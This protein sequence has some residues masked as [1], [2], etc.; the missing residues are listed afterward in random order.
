MIYLFNKK[1]HQESLADHFEYFIE[2]IL[3]VETIDQFKELLETI[4]SNKFFKIIYASLINIIILYK[5]NP[6]Q[7][8]VYNNCI[9]FPLNHQVY[10]TIL[11][12]SY[13]S[14][15]YNL[16]ITPMEPSVFEN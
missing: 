7:F 4:I 9:P 12:S 1:F 8:L 16:P 3:F 11:P 2:L 14:T 5:M 15:P 13:N 6:P 10:F